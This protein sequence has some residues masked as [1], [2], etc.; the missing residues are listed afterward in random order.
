MSHDIYTLSAPTYDLKL[1]YYMQN[2]AF[3]DVMLYSLQKIYKCFGD[4][5]QSSGSTE[6]S[7][8]FYQNKR[9]HVSEHSIEH[10][11]VNI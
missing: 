11:A 1:C 4:T 9:H 8:S 3:W 10:N 5:S 7:V 2:T 6:M